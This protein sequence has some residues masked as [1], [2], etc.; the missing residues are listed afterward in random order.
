MKDIS[1][2]SILRGATLTGLG[3][4]GVGAATPVAADPE[5]KIRK[6]LVGEEEGSSGDGDGCDVTVDPTSDAGPDTI[7]AGVDQASPGTRDDPTV[8]CVASGTYE[9]SVT[10]DKDGIALVGVNGVKNTTVEST[11]TTVSITGADVILFKLTVDGT[12]GTAVDAGPR[13][14]IRAC[15]IVADDT[16]TV[17][18]D[19]NP[20]SVVQNEFVDNSEFDDTGTAIQAADVRG[21]LGG[22]ADGIYVAGNT[23][24]GFRHAVELV[25]CKKVAVKSNTFELSWYSAIQVESLAGTPDVELLLVENN[26]FLDNT[27]AVILFEEGASAEIRDV[28]VVGNEFRDYFWGVLTSTQKVATDFDNDGEEEMVEVA[29]PLD[30]GVVDAQCNYWG[31]PT[32]PRAEGNDLSVESPVPA[33]VVPRPIKS[34]LDSVVPRQADMTV[35]DAVDYRPWQLEPP[36][37]TDVVPGWFPPGEWALP[38][39]HKTDCAGG[40]VTEEL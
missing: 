14:G 38:G 7:Q 11:G 10:V 21:E 13:T 35:E 39:E 12:A 22:K 34:G 30:G 2:R 28:G 36:T 40:A 8:V 18:S 27:N 5:D 29:G 37:V 15:R 9:E 31:R 6:L 24:S 26:E 32:G 33:W 23:F 25:D 17:T 3:A 20:L 4:V 16:T 19:A 1:R